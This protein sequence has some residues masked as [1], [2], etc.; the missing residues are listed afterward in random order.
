MYIF[1]QVMIN[2]NKKSDYIRYLYQSTK[3]L[4]YISSRS[5]PTL[6]N[7]NKKIQKDRIV[8]PIEIVYG[9]TIDGYN[10]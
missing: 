6:D 7:M 10:L 8:T 1:N 4:E 9:I 3:T 2:P 5:K